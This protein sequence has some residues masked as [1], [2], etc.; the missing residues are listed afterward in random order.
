MTDRDS[1]DASA[2]PVPPI[3]GIGSSAGGVEALLRL[4]PEIKAGGG[5]VYVVVQHLDP[6]HESVLAASLGNVAKIPVST[7]TDGVTIEPDHIYVIPPNTTLTIE[8]G[9]L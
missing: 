1:A 5:I 3:V 4:V 9:R 7:V 8:H 2:A 6:E